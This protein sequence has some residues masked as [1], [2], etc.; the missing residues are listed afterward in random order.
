MLDFPT[1]KRAWL[2]FLTA[3]AVAASFPSIAAVAGIPWPSF[4]PRPEVNLGLDL[5]GGSHILLEANPDQAADPGVGLKIACLYWRDHGC[6]ALADA[7]D[8][9]G[10]TRAINGGLTGLQDRAD[11][12]KE[13]KAIWP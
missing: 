1:W 10:V 3:V 9:E 8:L 6:N 12:L 13:A 4:M 5:A 7:D 2:W 11:R